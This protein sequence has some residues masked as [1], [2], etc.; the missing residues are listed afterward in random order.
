MGLDHD[1]PIHS[2]I[3]EG[4]ISEMNGRRVPTFARPPELKRHISSPSERR[5][6]AQ[7]FP[8]PTSFHSERCASCSLLSLLAVTSSL[9][10][11]EY[12]CSG[13][14]SPSPLSRDAGKCDT[15]VVDVLV[16]YVS[17]MLSGLSFVAWPS[18]TFFE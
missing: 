3:H 4:F 6:C 15:V 17:F 2:K 8:P 13:S 7:I 1:R 18:L 9:A 14:I 16:W 12:D 5:L 10:V 11:L